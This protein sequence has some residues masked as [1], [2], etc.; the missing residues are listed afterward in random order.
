MGKRLD[1]GK[2]VAS[3]HNINKLNGPS[4]KLF[5]LLKEY[6][7]GQILTKNNRRDSVMIESADNIQD[8]LDLQDTK[9]DDATLNDVNLWNE[10]VEELKDCNNAQI[11]Y[12]VKDICNKSDKLINYKEIFVSYFEYNNVNGAILTKMKREEFAEAVAS[13]NTELTGPS[14]K[15]FQA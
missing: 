12:L 3:Y 14:S 6:D 2:A 8:I 5:K 13:Y 1:F 9:Q 7:F 4:T 11:V 10:P 15:L